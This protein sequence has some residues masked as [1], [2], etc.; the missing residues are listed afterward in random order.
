MASSFSPQ[1]RNIKIILE[2]DG[3]EYSGWQRQKNAR[4]VQEECEKALSKVAQGTITLTGSGRTDSGVHALG[5]VANFFTRSTLDPPSLMRGANSLLPEDVRIIDAEE[6]G[7][8]FNARRDAVLRWYQYRIINRKIA[9]ALYRRYYTHVPYRLDLHKMRAAAR[10]LE[11]THDFRAF[12]SILCTA[13][14]TSLTLEAIAIFTEADRI[15]L[16]F[17]CRSFLHN[18]VRIITGAFIEIARGK[19]PMK[20]LD[21]MLATGIRPDNI[22]TASPEGLFLMSVVYPDTVAEKSRKEY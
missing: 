10:K 14:R 1:E 3:T 6:V 5:Q 18:M 7:R 19:I 4:T 9:P 11:G 17:R 2:Y 15:L 21:E 13:K 16:D 20:T 22:P 12:R 8:E